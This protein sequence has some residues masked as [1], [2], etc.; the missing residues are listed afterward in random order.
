[1]RRAVG[2]VP[3]YS[4]MQGHKAGRIHTLCT[5]QASL[6]IF[7]LAILEQYPQ[8]ISDAAVF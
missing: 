6:L 8:R 7:L 2:P 4:H 1:M 5:T 3:L